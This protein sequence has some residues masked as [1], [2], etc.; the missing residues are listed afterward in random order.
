MLRHFLAACLA[1]LLSE[2]LAHHL[3][4]LL[5][6]SLCVLGVECIAPHTFVKQAEPCIICDDVTHVAVL[7][8]P[9]SYLFGGRDD[10]CPHRSGSSVGNCFELERLFAPCCCLFIDLFEHLFHLRRIHVAGKL[11]L[12]A[13]WMHGRS[14]DP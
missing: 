2:V 5:P 12:Y 3:F 14:A 1:Q 6:E 11:S 7:A 9:S 13:P 10:R 8:I 4:A